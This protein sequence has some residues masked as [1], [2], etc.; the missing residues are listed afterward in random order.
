MGE[1]TIQM[2]S[3][4]MMNRTLILNVK[5]TDW[6]ITQTTN[7]RNSIVQVTNMGRQWKE[8]GS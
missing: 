8:N 3:L 2:K 1:V 6:E 4:Q 7:M 5:V